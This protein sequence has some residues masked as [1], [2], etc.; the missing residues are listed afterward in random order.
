MKARSICFA[1]LSSLLFN[2]A[3][4]IFA[5]SYAFSTLAGSASQGSLDGSA[6]NARFFA[7]QGVCVDAR[8]NVYVADSDN[9][10]IREITPGG[11]VATIAGQAGVYGY[12]DGTGTNALF[13]LPKSLAVDASGDLYVVDTWNQVIR[14]LTPVGTNWVVSTLAG[15]AGNA[16]YADATGTNA[17]F[18]NPA[19]AAVDA[20]GNVYVT[21]QNNDVIRKITPLGV[22]TTIAGQVGSNNSLD[23]TNG[24]A[25]FA[26]PVGIAIDNATNL[27]VADGDNTIRRIMP[28]GTN[29]VVTTIAGQA[30]NYG[31]TN[32]LGT[33]ALF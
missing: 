4:P 5:Q 26:S 1:V 13:F 12:A 20:A 29:W 28:V 33:N 14:K 9:S 16:G 27:Y 2:F 32:G 30:N 6:T 11:L 10:T 18:S 17:Q 24:N 8:S 21:D 3:T 19:Y 23:G 31:S 15:Q 7:P 25:Q 22:V